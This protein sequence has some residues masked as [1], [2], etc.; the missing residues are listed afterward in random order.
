ML[1]SPIIS[2]IRKKYN[3]VYPAVNLLGL[4]YYKIGYDLTRCLHLV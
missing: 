4:C 1:L 2:Y 3:S